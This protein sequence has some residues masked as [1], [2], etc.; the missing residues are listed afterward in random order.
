[1][2]IGKGFLPLLTLSSA[3]KCILEGKTNEQIEEK[4]YVPNWGRVAAVRANVTRGNIKLEPEKPKIMPIQKEQEEKPNFCKH[5]ISRDKYKAMPKSSQM[6]IDYFLEESLGQ[7]SER[8]QESLRQAFTDS[9]L[10]QLINPDI[11]SHRIYAFFDDVSIALMK[12]KKITPEYLNDTYI[13]I[14]NAGSLVE[15]V[16]YKTNEPKE[17]EPTKQKKNIIPEKIKEE[18][19]DLIVSGIPRDEVWE[20]YKNHFE[21]RLQFGAVTAW[22]SPNLAKKRV[23]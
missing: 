22:A 15:T 12:N 5:L 17:A 9:G 3:R 1:V 2:H 11:D 16:K 6:R 21:S 10:S 19:R 4:Y 7:L 20:T 14:R 18:I 13:S 23:N 8:K